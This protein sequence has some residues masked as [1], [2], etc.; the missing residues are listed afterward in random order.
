[1]I[2]LTAEGLD[3]VFFEIVVVDR[4]LASTLFT[5]AFHRAIRPQKSPYPVWIGAGGAD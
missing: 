2:A 3:W 1:M 4:R 5:E